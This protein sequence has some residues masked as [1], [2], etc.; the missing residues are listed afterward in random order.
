MYLCVCLSVCGWVPVFTICVW[1]SEG[2]FTWHG[3]GCLLPSEKGPLTLRG[4]LSGWL[5][6]ELTGLY[7]SLPPAS[8]LWASEVYSVSSF[9]IRTQLRLGR[10]A[11]HGQSHLQVLEYKLKH[12]NL[13]FNPGLNNEHVTFAMERGPWPQKLTRDKHLLSNE[14][15]TKR[16]GHGA[17][18]NL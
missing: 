10:Q 18:L 1:R 3:Q 16:K 15:E 4:T 6:C 2:N 9:Q 12:R 11:L 5:A 14:A 8:P 13:P 7:L 17:Y